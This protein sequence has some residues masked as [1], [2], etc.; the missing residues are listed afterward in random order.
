MQ[1][2]IAI[3]GL[4]KGLAR[5]VVHPANLVH[6]LGR[7]ARLGNPI[8][9]EHGGNGFCETGI[10]V[11]MLVAIDVGRDVANKNDETFNLEGMRAKR[12]TCD[13]NSVTTSSTRI[14]ASRSAAVNP[15]FPRNCTIPSRATTSDGMLDGFDTATPSEMLK[16]NPMH[17]LA[18]FAF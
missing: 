12:T 14:T 13:L 10:D 17:K 3:N 18:S 16:C 4:A 11:D 6:V 9:L 8:F 1:G 15:S 5:V 2:H 7:K